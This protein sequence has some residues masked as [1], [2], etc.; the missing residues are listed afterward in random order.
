M[1]KKR[2]ERIH[3]HTT[4]TKLPDLSSKSRLSDKYLEKPEGK[5]KEKR[6]QAGKFSYFEEQASAAPLE[7]CF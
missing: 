3:K 5:K 4:S 7:S 6:I 2:R 1:R